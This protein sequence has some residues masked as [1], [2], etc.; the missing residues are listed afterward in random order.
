M[1]VEMQKTIHARVTPEDEA[2]IREIARRLSRRVSDVVRCAADPVILAEVVR[3]S[4]EI[5]AANG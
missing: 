1:S 2:R 3:V 5:E 4:A